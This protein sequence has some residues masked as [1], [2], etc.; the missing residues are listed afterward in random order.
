MKKR[1]YLL[2][3]AVILI[4]VLLSG[5]LWMTAQ[6]GQKVVVT[7]EG[8]ACGSYSLKKDRTI[9][10]GNGNRLRIQNGKA[11]MEWAS[12]PDQL[13]VHQKDISKAGE[14]IICLPHRVVISVEG[15]EKSELDSIVN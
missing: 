1:D 15:D 13:C 2:I 10:I 12:C 7:V 11:R 9:E 4:A 6:K 14:S 8:E 5:I 3:G